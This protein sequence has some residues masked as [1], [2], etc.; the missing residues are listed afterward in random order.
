LELG[1]YS[2]QTTDAKTQQSTA[3][4]IVFDDEQVVGMK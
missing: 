2:E 4:A 1:A 3:E